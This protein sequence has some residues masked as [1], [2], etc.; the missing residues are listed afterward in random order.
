METVNHIWQ[1]DAA[2]NITKI[3]SDNNVAF[4]IANKNSP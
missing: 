3:P 1:Y 4:S 2:N